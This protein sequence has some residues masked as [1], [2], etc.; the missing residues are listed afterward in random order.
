MRRARTGPRWAYLILTLWMALM[1]TTALAALPGQGGGDQTASAQTL[2]QSLDEVIKTLE[3]DQDRKALLDS[4]KSLQQANAAREGAS[5][6]GSSGLLGAL[7]DSL[8]QLDNGE[9][10][11]FLDRWRAQAIEAWKNLSQR[12]TFDLTAGRILGDFLITLGCWLGLAWALKWLIRFLVRHYEWPMAL[13]EEPSLLA[14]TRFFLRRALPWGIAFGVTLGAASFLP[15]TP[16]ITLGMTVAYIGLAGLLFR[17]ICDIIFSLFGYGHRRTAQRILRKRALGRLFFIA[18]LAAMSDAANA[19]ELRELMGDGLAGFVSELS[20]LVAVIIAGIFII[21]FKRPIRHLIQNSDYPLRKKRSHLVEFLYALGRIWHI[22]ATLFVTAL[23]VSNITLSGDARNAFTKAVLTAVVL[24]V[25][26]I[27]NGLLR[28]DEQRRRPDFKRRRHSLYW[29]RLVRFGYILAQLL[30]WV[31]FLEIALRFWGHSLTETRSP[32][33]LW[34][35]VLNTILSLGSTLLLAWFVWIILDT[36]IQQAL[37][38]TMKTHR[39]RHQSTRAQT[40]APLIRNVV[41]VTIAVIT[42]IVILANLGVNVT[43]LLAGAGVIGL[44]VG[45]GAQTLVQDLIT[46]VFILIEDTLAIDDFVDVGGH[47][48]TV[49]KLSI[50]TVRL[51]DLDGIVHSIPFSQIKSIQN[52]SREFGIA[53]FRIRIPHQLKIDDAIKMIQEVADELR[54]DTFGRFYIWSPLEFQGIESFDNGAA[55]LRAQFRTS[56]VMQ[57]NVAREF[58]LRLKRRMEA[59][60]VDMAMSRMS[61]QMESGGPNKGASAMQYATPLPE[62]PSPGD[63]PN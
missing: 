4:L 45:F 11:S 31:L 34:Q 43:P 38:S 59:D 8:D 19:P 58:N 25:V 47:M 20:S 36:A 29:R 14:I 57:W 56:P 35:Y 62:E 16:G 49:E 21:R 1:S 24:V 32:T 26:L 53:L 2:N 50:R 52:F 42:L 48:G 18:A 41:F 10:L 30:S 23:F 27:S 22:P 13:P 9:N 6:G 51:R 46:G 63:G 55:I 37:K 7:A 54:Q 17:L 39:G 40:I 3:N 28:R 60:G 5:E 15:T 44:A 12:L 33:V 61:V